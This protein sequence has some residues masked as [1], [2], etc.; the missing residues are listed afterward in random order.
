[1]YLGECKYLAKPENYSTQAVSLVYE[2]LGRRRVE[3]RI[4]IP[5]SGIVPGHRL[6]F[7]LFLFS[8][9]TFVLWLLQ[10]WRCV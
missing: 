4:F 9:S 1:V 2:V 7:F 8:V 10:E 6:C 5:L 3:Y